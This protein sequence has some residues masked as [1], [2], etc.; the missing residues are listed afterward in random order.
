MIA[1]LRR[2]KGACRLGK[3]ATAVLI[4]TLPV[5][6]TAGAR[7]QPAP[8]WDDICFQA[9]KAAAREHGIPTALMS[10]IA[11]VETGRSRQGRRAPWPWAINVE[12]KGRYLPDRHSLEREAVA[13]AARGASF[14]VGCFQVNHRWHGAA[15]ASAADMADPALN[16]SYAARFL[17]AL[18]AE[19]GDWMTAVGYYHSRTPHLAARYRNLVVAALAHLGDTM[20][21]GDAVRPVPAARRSDSE[22]FAVAHAV[23]RRA[24]GSLFQDIDGASGP[25]GRR[26]GAPLAG[27]VASDD[28]QA[29]VRQRRGSTVPRLRD[30]PS[31]F[32]AMEKP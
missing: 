18:A 5:A 12:G 30:R 15:F 23:R 16:A 24:A 8:P 20:P 21:E 25:V 10:A 26:L 1:A 17:A 29:V 19:T 6:A 13:L 2:L 22:P 32:A 11:M 4:A 28:G 9:G 7:A 31:L 14:D 27:R 3:I